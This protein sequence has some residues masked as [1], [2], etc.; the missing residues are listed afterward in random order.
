M[1]YFGELCSV[2]LKEAT[3]TTH[4]LNFS[5]YSEAENRAAIKYCFY[6]YIQQALRIPSSRYK[7]DHGWNMHFISVVSFHGKQS[8]VVVLF[9]CNST[10]DGNLD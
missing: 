6:F 5:T 3:Q 4:K 1:K 2:A 10:Y 8:C 9:F 7:S